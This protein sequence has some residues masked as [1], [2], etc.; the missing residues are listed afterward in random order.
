M[1]RN[2]P[3]EV[4]L[5]SLRVHHSFSQ[6]SQK[7]NWFEVYLFFYR[8]FYY[9]KKVEQVLGRSIAGKSLSINHIV[10]SIKSRLKLKILSI[11][12]IWITSR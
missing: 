4:D 5:L 8:M 9:S 12:R 7:K 3:I 1:V 10:L 2:R 6:Y 11:K